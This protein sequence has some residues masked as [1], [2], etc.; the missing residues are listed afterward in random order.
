[1]RVRLTRKL[2]DW[3]DG[4][5][6]SGHQEGDVLTLTGRKAQLLVAEGWAQPLSGGSRG[7]MRV[8]CAAVEQAEPAD[9]QRT[10]NVQRLQ[11]LRRD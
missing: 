2:A 9:F 3:V 8:G 10:I 11:H 4:V 7:E 6:L 1:M 5:D